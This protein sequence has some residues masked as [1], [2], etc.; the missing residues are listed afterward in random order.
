MAGFHPGMWQF[1]VALLVLNLVL[2][3]VLFFIIDRGRLVS[4]AYSR[5]DRRNL[6]KLQ[7]ARLDAVRFRTEARAEAGAGGGD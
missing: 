4:P 6:A 7:S 2:V 3:F 5:L 1:S